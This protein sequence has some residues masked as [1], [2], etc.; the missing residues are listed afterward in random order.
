LQT[1]IQPSKESPVDK[2]KIGYRLMYRF[3][4]YDVFYHPAIVQGR[5]DYLM[6][7]DED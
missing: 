3:W 7:M 1:S 6:R 4:T 5:Y 2:K